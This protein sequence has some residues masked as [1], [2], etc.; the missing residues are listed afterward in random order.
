MDEEAWKVV[1]FSSST[2]PSVASSSRA[3]ELT[4]TQPPTSHAETQPPESARADAGIASM[5]GIC[6]ADPQER[7][8]Q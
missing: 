6:L 3:L 1:S 7:Q 5:T 4:I 2:T 8:S